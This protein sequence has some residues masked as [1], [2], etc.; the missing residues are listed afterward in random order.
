[1]KPAP[2]RGRTVLVVEDDEVIGSCICDV[3]KSEGYVAERS[4]DGADALAWL[5]AHRDRGPSVLIVDLVMP[6]VDGW[7]F[8]E[9]V[10]SD[11]RLARVP[12]VIETAADVPDAV[13]PAASV[14]LRKPFGVE[15]LVAALE[16]CS[17]GAEAR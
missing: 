17:R 6:N 10:R 5:A 4:A 16:V 9:R 11:P 8:L 13:L 14:R 1:M 2:G 15:E 12:V 7:E 3:A